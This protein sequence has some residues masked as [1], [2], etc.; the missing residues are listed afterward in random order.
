MNG[1]NRN[2]CYSRKQIHGVLRGSLESYLPTFNGVVVAGC[3]RQ[4]TNPDAPAV[5]LPGN[6]P[7]IRESAELFASSAVIIPVFIKRTV[8]KWCYVG[9]FRVSRLST[10]QD[11]IRKH[12]NKTGRMD[13]SCVL[14]LDEV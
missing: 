5:I 9:N 12:T 8:N 6:G 13:V 4:D 3:F 11:E 7:R 1:F 2:Q 10:D 14:Y